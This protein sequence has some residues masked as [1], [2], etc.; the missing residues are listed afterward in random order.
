VLASTAPFVASGTI[1]S[2]AIAVTAA[3]SGEFG[4]ST[5]K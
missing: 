3:L 5:P 4:A 1:V 2:K